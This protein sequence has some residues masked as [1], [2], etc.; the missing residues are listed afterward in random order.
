MLARV[1]DARILS[2]VQERVNELAAGVQTGPG[3]YMDPATFRLEMQGILDAA[4]YRPEPGREG[5]ISDLRTKA[6]LDLIVQTETE[7]ASGRAQQAADY[8]ADIVD[9]FPAW[10]LYRARKGKTSR[11][12]A[13]RWHTAATASGDVTALDALNDHDRMIARK[14]S[15]I[16]AA[17]GSTDLFDDALDTDH[18]P[19]A[20]S[21]GMAVRNVSRST[22]VNMGVIA[23][24]ERVVVTP[25]EKPAPITANVANISPAIRAALMATTPDAT[26]DDSGTLLAN[27]DSQA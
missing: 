2:A 9:A 12:W 8:D 25:P 21:S 18:P 10:E 24:G 1:A 7:L 17:L 23:K 15:P 22:A 4:D 11:D 27:P 5:T 13:E 20:F 16:W 26:T 3:E 19:F 6:R 14:D